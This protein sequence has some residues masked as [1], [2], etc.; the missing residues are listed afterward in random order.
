MWRMLY[1]TSTHHIAASKHRDMTSRHHQIAHRNILAGQFSWLERRPVKSDHFGSR[2]SPVGRH[3]GTPASGLHSALG[4]R[5][6]LFDTRADLC[7][8]AGRLGLFSE[9]GAWHRIHH[10]REPQAG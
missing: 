10:W 4:E 2:C 1:T 6:A 7:A 5:H 8:H 9:A 3:S